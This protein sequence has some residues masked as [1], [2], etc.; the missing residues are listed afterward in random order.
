MVTVAAALLD[1]LG[2]W[3]GLHGAGDI[4][5]VPVLALAFIATQRVLSVAGNAMK[6][7][8]EYRATPTRCD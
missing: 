1:T 3:G 6:R 4:A 5:V 2:H 7:G 8:M